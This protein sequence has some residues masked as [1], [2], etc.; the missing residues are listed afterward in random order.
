MSHEI[1]EAHSI[2]L[3]DGEHIV[4][5]VRRHMFVFY[6]RILTLF[7][8]ALLP[9]IFFTT[10][11]NIIS[12]ALPGQG[13]SI[14]G[15]IYLLFLLVLIV[16]FFFQWTDY[17]LDVWI[18]T[19]ERI[20]DINQRGMFTREIS[21][22]ELERIQ[23]VNVKI[24]GLLATLLKFGDVHIHTAGV[25]EDIIIKEAARPLAVKKSILDE[26]ARHRNQKNNI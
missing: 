18:I 23:D 22:F 26:Y 4:A 10:V 12:N 7:I 2:D 1:A 15:V 24:K 13:T 3:R 20:F 11:A 25:K 16:V 14:T 8:L 9:L 5:E 17:Y 6:A 19:S 21:V